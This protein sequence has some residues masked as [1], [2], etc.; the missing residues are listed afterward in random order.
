MLKWKKKHRF[1][2]SLSSLHSTYTHGLKMSSDLYVRY[3]VVP[4][5]WKISL[6]FQV[7]ADRLQQLGLS[8]KSFIYVCSSGY[9]NNTIV[10][11]KVIETKS[12]YYDFSSVTFLLLCKKK[13]YYFCV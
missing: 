3:A 5:G 9:G 6:D 4:V 12:D 1:G 7:K 2:K 13:Q 11:S 10:I 8:L